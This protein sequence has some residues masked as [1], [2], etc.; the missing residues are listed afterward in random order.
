MAELVDKFG[1]IDANTAREPFLFEILGEIS[2][3]QELAVKSGT[4]PLATLETLSASRNIRIPFSPARE[5]AIAYILDLLTSRFP[6]QVRT[7]VTFDF[8]VEEGTK[9]LSVPDTV[10]YMVLAKDRDL[11]EL[12]SR[13]D[14]KSLESLLGLLRRFR[15]FNLTKLLK[16]TGR[17]SD[18]SRVIELETDKQIFIFKNYSIDKNKVEV[19]EDH[20]FHAQN[21]NAARDSLN[22]DQLKNIIGYFGEPV[23]RRLRQ[24]GIVSTF[25]S[26]YRDPKLDYILN[27]LINELQG[28]LRSSDLVAVKNFHAL[29]AC[30]VRVESLLD[31]LQTLGRDIAKC[32][33]EDRICSSTDLCAAIPTLAPEAVEKWATPENLRNYRIVTYLDEEGTI[34][35]MDGRKFQELFAEMKDLVVGQPERLLDMAYSERQRVQLHLDILYRTAKNIL[36]S[37]DKRKELNL[38]DEHIELIKKA[39]EEYEGHLEKARLKDESLRRTQL[40]SAGKKGIFERIIDFL[41]RLFGRRKPP[42]PQPGQP[43]L[44]PRPSYSRETRH[45][46]KKVANQKGPVLV[47]SEF[48][49]LMP[50]NDHLVDFLIN[51]MRENNLRIV[52]PVY[53]AREALYPVR[54]QKVLIPD[55]EFVL[56]PPE[57][58]RSPESIRKYTDSLVGFKLK[59]EVI[60]SKGIMAVEKYLLTLYRQKRSQMIKKEL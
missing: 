29:R 17:K 53:N 26:D 50:E 59:D 40:Q 34:H 4:Q 14:E 42:Q 58:V 13:R 33:A 19:A 39:V 11:E 37:L 41:R 52:V 22:L 6:E 43:G 38:S 28:M 5:K 55:I 18:L 31:P 10:E 2:R 49:D 45:V 56:V 35:F 23:M 46:Y 48:I 24:Y 20:C 54:S 60:P 47:L 15:F 7:I 3:I 44:E 57:T 16:I 8:R 12:R 25:V 36:S 9:K 1:F 51:E 27:I 32:I 21:Y 30:L